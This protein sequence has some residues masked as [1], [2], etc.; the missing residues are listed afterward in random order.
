MPPFSTR[1]DHATCQ[2]CQSTRLEVSE[3]SDTQPIFR[4][5]VKIAAFVLSAVKRAKS[6]FSAQRRRVIMAHAGFETLK[7]PQRDMV[8]K[9]TAL[10]LFRERPCQWV[11]MGASVSAILASS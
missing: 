9:V 5:S 10:D 11:P 3:Q 2:S 1:S 8:I 4:L 6:V 7:S